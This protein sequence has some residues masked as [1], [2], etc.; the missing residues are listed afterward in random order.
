MSKGDLAGGW[1]K[2]L[3]GDRKQ[4][5]MFFDKMLDG[6]SYHRIAVDKAGK[7]VDYVFLEV[8]HAFE[9]M[10]G[11]KRE[12]I[13]GKKVTDVLPGIEKDP[14]DW[15]GVYGKVALTGE[16]VQ[17]ENYAAPLGTWYRVI[18]YSPEK[19][20]FVALFE[21][22][23]E[24]KKAEQELWQTK[25]DWERTFDSVPDFIA[26]LNNQH[27]IVRV[28]HAMAQQLGVAPEKAIGLFCYQC[29]H[30]LDNP[31]AF[32]PHSQ[33]VKDGEEHQA[34][35][36]EPRLGGDFL[37]S[38]TPLKDEQGKIIGSVHVAR[39]ITERKRAEEALR[40]S[41]ERYRQLLQYAPAAIY[42]IDFNGPRFK[43]VN[44]A[45]C[46]MSGYSREELLAMNPFDA[47]DAESLERFKE[48]IRKALAGEK[49]D[50]NVEYKAVRKDGRQFWVT[51]NMKLTSQNGR[52]YGAQ[53]IA[54]D[55][56]ERKKAEEALRKLNRHLKAV[57]NSNQALMHAADESTFTQ[58][59]CNIII[60]D[61]GYALVW[62]GFAEHDKDK[63]VCPVA[64]AGFDKDYIDALNVTWDEKSKRGHGP[65]GTVIRT[66]KPYIC[67]NMQIDPNFEPWRS[68]ALKRGYTASLV[69]PLTTFEGKTFGALNIYSKEPDPFADEE[70]KLLSELASDFSYGVGMLRLRNE[71][72]QAEKTL[73]KQASLIDLSPDAIIVRTFEGIINFWSKGAE[74]LYG[75][76]KQEAIGQDI[77]VL[78]KT[79]FPVP[80]EEIQNQLKL[81]GKW[82]GEIV[83]TCKNGGKVVLQSYWSAKFDADGNIVETM[84]SNVDITDRVELQ[85]KL[86]ESAVRVEE[87]A[88][89]MEELAE[90]RAAQLKDAERLAAI[91][92]TAG[93]VGHDIRNPLQAITGD[94]YLAKTELVESPNCDGKNRALESIAEIEKNVDYINKI[95]ADLQDYARPLNPR[96]QQ[97]SVKS[98]FNDVL[99]KNGVS[100]NVKVTVEVEDKADKVMADPD[101]LKRIAANLTLN[102]VQ[103]MPNGGELI[104]RGYVDTQTQDTLITVKD[105]GVGIPENVKPKLFT[106]MMTTKSKGQGFGL[107]VVKRM[108]EA[109]GGTVTFESTEGKGTTF[110]IRLPPLREK[111]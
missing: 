103:A 108:T 35:V 91:G 94:L 106:P 54:H 62:V 81:E 90:K 16:P 38:T 6:F 68:A 53:V 89:Q 42:E 36:H 20:Y 18:A 30:D 29:V 60:N 11:L 86:E 97:T 28:N 37:V 110:I 77:N 12:K 51:L 75:L 27:R 10:T 5:D 43:N 74:K 73:R 71:R 25:N 69:L 34:E 14:A 7:P 72:E 100:E 48:R 64:F 32:C 24:R 55:I 87:Y 65:T 22:I 45:M 49:I 13:I 26:I 57:S 83:H 102:A 50:E 66:G 80:L 78:L 3:G 39:N 1:A 56:T 8:N 23:T 59:V 31:P 98:V 111:R 2:A 104:I 93:M 4:F 61:C 52:F 92:A 67:K 84:E 17:F 109:L 99:A 105:T 76:N 101:Y 33:T 70:M 9:K 44:E 85:V 15:I 19:G 58:E 47:L 82:S 41:E 63:T 46:I 107:P 95:V 40:A 79:E 21:N 96:S 88:N